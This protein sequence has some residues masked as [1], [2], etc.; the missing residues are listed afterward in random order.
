MLTLNP[1]VRAAEDGTYEVLIPLGEDAK[2]HV[3][4]YSFHSEEAGI[5]WI[6]SRKG[7]DRI[8]QAVEIFKTSYDYRNSLHAA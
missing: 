2:P 7:K 3:L 1:Y 5:A 4:P 8:R 6:S